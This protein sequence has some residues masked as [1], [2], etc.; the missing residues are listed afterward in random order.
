M[1]AT[2]LAAAMQPQAPTYR[3]PMS[4]HLRGMIDAYGEAWGYQWRHNFGNAVRIPIPSILGRFI[5]EGFAAT[6]GKNKPRSYPEVF[7]GMGLLFAVVLKDTNE[8]DREIA[9]A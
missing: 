9:F 2:N 6:D 7:L 8:R 5:T 4:K 1:I 3:E